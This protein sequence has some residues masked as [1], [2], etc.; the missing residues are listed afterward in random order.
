M[1]VFI[2]SKHSQVF[3]ISKGGWHQVTSEMF[4]AVIAYAKIQETHII[5]GECPV[6]HKDC[7]FCFIERDKNAQTQ[8]AK[9]VSQEDVETLPEA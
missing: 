2:C 8:T 1:Q 7:P 4:E 9:E 3:R 5:E 6:C